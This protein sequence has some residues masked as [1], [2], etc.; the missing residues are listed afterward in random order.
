[1][2]EGWNN[3]GFAASASSGVT[4]AA[5]TAMEVG[6]TQ[7]SSYAGSGDMSAVAFDIRKIVVQLSNIAGTPGPAQ[8]EV[9]LT[10][11]Q[12]G[13]NYILDEPLT[14]TVQLGQGDATQGTA[15]IP[16]ADC[17]G[18]EVPPRQITTKS[19]RPGSQSNRGVKVWAWVKLDSGTADVVV[20]VISL[21]S[22]N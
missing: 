15:V 3:A 1:M 2:V 6:G 7:I 17:N 20:R 4:A 16:L 9:L 13:N 11:D 22:G 19:V 10:W 21:N 18:F 12:A 5:F 8:V 14:G